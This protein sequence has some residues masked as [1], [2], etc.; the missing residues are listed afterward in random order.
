MSNAKKGKIL[1]T[2]HKMA[3]I[4]SRDKIKK[5]VIEFNQYGEIINEYESINAAAH[6]LNCSRSTIRSKINRN[7]CFAFK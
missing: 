3:I 5:S 4:N 6:E 7:K 1:S 2:S